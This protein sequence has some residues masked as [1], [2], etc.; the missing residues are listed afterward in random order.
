MQ[1]VANLIY[2]AQCVSC[3][4]RV[5]TDYALCGACWRDTPFIA[6]L[7]CD[8][9]G[10]PLPGTDPGQPVHCD[11]CMA[12]ARPWER[13]RA[14]MLYRDNGRRLVLG[15][16]H[17]DRTDLARPAGRWMAAVAGP[18]LRPETLVIP[19]PVHWTRLA[20]RRYSQAALLA[21][22][23]A[24]AAALGWLPDALI[25]PR[26]TPMLDGKTRDERF[27]TLAEAIRPH[28]KR[29]ARLAGRDVLI[30][31]DVMT[32]G[33]TLAATADAARAAGAARVSVLVLARVAKDA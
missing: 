28:P 29:G 1:S 8:L 26:R 30:V 15:L 13:G 31:D 20:R 18:V 17:G 27:A 14:A 19:V 2:P 7:V 9:C 10:V 25:R 12:I 33:A 3:D 5:E 22:E 23:V 11:D 21:A 24:R 6:G 4:A 32:S 16:K